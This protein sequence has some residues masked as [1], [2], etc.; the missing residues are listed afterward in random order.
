MFSFFHNISRFSN[1]R[2]P[3]SSLEMQALGL[4]GMERRR[5]GGGGVI[6]SLFTNKT[7]PYNQKLCKHNNTDRWINSKKSK[8]KKTFLKFIL[9]L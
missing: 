6:Y 8:Q 4:D 5:R 3:V 9:V 2:L 1:P 7:F